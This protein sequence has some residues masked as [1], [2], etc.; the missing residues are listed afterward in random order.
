[1]NGRDIILGLLVEK[2]RTGYEI[3][4]HFKTVFSHYYQ[5]SYG[6]IYPTL[7]KLQNEGFVE[8]KTIIQDGKPN[9]NLFIINEEGKKEFEKSLSDGIADDTYT[10]EFLVRMYFGEYISHEVIG[11]LIL[12]QID[13]IELRIAQLSEDLVEWETVINDM[14]RLTYEIRLSHY[15]VELKILRSE[16]PKYQK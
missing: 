7:N 8:K 11:D 12:E 9:K 13:K 6:M 3:N 4:K 16:L 2:S 10:S 14:Q 15:Q 5:T 1:M